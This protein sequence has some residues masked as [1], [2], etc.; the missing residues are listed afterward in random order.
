VKE[1]QDHLKWQAAELLLLA[2]QHERRLQKQLEM[3][4]VIEVEARKLRVQ[5]AEML[6]KEKEI[7]RVVIEDMVGHNNL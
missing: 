1:S 4:D 6:G 7:K 2:F 5:A 3:E